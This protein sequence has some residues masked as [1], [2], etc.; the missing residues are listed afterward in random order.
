LSRNFVLST[1]FYQQELLET[2]EDAGAISASG[3]EVYIT[4]NPGRG[5]HADSLSM[6][7]YAEPYAHARR[8]YNAFEVQLDRRFAN[9]TTSRQLHNSRLRGNYSGLANSDEAGRSDPGVNRSF[10]LPHIGFTAAGGDD[11]GPLATDVRTL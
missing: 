2:V 6:F 11:Y 10:D 8:D 1:R 4:G 7:G 3:S 5:L 9:N